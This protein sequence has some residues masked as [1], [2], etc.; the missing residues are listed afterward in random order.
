[1]LLGFSAGGSSDEIGR[2][3]CQRLS[4]K[5]GQPFIFDNRPGAGSNIAI[6]IVA[7][8]ASDGYSLLWCTSANA[9]NTTL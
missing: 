4:E 5:L 8:E 9:I 6:E 2:L 3:I 7:R 1:M